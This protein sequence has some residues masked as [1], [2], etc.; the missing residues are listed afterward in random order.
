MASYKYRASTLNGTIKKGIREASDE[1][2]LKD[3]LRS[4]NL[5]LISCTEYEKNIRSRRLKNMEL[6]DFFR[7]MAAM[8]DSGISIFSALDILSQRELSPNMTKVVATML[9]LVKIGNPLS[10]AMKETNGAFPPIAISMV[11][12][13]EA[14]GNS[15]QI[16]ARL[17]DHFENENKTSGTIKG[18]MT[19]PIILLCLLI[20]A[21]IAIFTF[22]LPR[23]M[24]VFNGMEVEMP[25][26]TRIVIG[27]SNFF[28][29]KWFVLVIAAV[30]LFMLI[31][32]LLSMP[33]VQIFLTKS[34][35]HAGKIGHLLSIIFSARFCRTF[36]SLYS[37]GLSIISACQISRSTI[38]CPYIAS[39]F[40]RVISDIRQGN[41][42]SDSIGRVDG[43]DVKLKSTIHIGEE[44]GRLETMLTTTADAYEYESEQSIKKLTSLIEP[45]MICFMG[46]II[47]FVFVSVMLPI[48][49][50]YAS[51]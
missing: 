18:A 51:I 37:S 34:L 16:F 31:S 23:F 42:I 4:E 20:V 32:S 2:Q 48:Y 5:Y 40:D 27:I 29:Q 15:N 35:L 12:A 36:S 25:L 46:A 17:A 24:S 41:T 38:G 28:T 3:V 14:S 8:I 30:I 50:L 6:S 39:Q 26:P 7:Q 9:H 10:D 21:V 43:F 49:N 44:S 11:E 13:G 47:A 19:Y 22:I 1:L 45:I 33:K